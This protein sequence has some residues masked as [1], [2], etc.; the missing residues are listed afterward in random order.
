ME[1]EAINFS[2]KPSNEKCPHRSSGFCRR[3]AISCSGAQLINRS[4]WQQCP[5]RTPTSFHYIQ[6]YHPII[7]E[8]QGNRNLQHIPPYGYFQWMQTLT[9]SMN[10]WNWLSM[11]SCPCPLLNWLVSPMYRIF[12]KPHPIAG[13]QGFESSSS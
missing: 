9:P 10:S 7:I 11:Q 6:A 2:F 8:D 3:S 5:D 12:K 13:Y 1:G 4:L